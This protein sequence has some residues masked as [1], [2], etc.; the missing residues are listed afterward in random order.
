MGEVKELGKK[1]KEWVK[2]FWKPVGILWVII[3]VGM[4]AILR[5]NFSYMDDLARTVEGYK[6]W[7]NFSRYLSN[8]LAMIV[9]GNTTVADISPWPQILAAL[10]MAIAGVMLLYVIYDRKKFRWWE[11]AVV[12]IL[13]L[14]PYFLECLSYKFDAPYIAVAILAMIVPVLFRKK[15]TG[16][17]MLA[18]M[19]GTLVTCMTYQA[20]LG[21]LPMLVVLVV[22]RMWS[23]KESMK[24]IGRFGAWSAIGYVGGLVIFRVFLMKQVDAYVE[25]RL[26]GIGELLPTVVGNL[27]EYYR[28]M[29]MDFPKIWVGLIGLVVLGFVVM[30]AIRSERKVWEAG[31]VAVLALVVMSLVCFGIYPLMTQPLFEP[32]AMFGV[33]VMVAMLGVVVVEDRNNNVESRRWR[34]WQSM[35]WG[36]FVAVALALSYEFGIFG[37]MY[38]NALSLQSE[39]TDFRIEAAIDD[40]E[41]V[42]LDD[43]SGFDGGTAWTEKDPEK[44]SVAVMGTVGVAPALEDVIVRFPILERL[45][46]IEFESGYW[47]EYK[48][49]RYYG[50]R[51]L[52]GDPYEA[53]KTEGCL[54]EKQGYYQDIWRCSHEKIVVELKEV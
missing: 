1:F 50:L 30:M 29:L 54:K 34:G 49:F 47:G 26:P 16:W 20:A 8:F 40:L 25:T 38:G 15:K 6:G 22:M 2:P 19:M 23:Q 17:Y 35:I 27:R 4:F 41:D 42:V 43:W 9:N 32:R 24:E 44:V 18:V 13:A 33:M 21:V 3:A 7:G 11:L 5:A 12:A 51:A 46:P 28:L 36:G 31:I 45:V 53:V 10:I 39:Y 48:L 52:Q 14:N 37:F